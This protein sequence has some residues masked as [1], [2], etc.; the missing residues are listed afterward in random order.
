MEDFELKVVEFGED[1]LA[2]LQ[3]IAQA[4]LY[5]EEDPRSINYKR[6]L[7]RPRINWLKICVF[8]LIPFVVIAVVFAILYTCDIDFIV[9][10]GIALAFFL[11]YIVIITKRT[12]ICI[13]KLYQ[14]FAP[15]S[16]R[17]KCR[18]EPSCSEY[19]IISIEK[20]GLRKGMKAGIKRLKRC[21]TS[22]GGYDYP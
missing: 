5:D 7:V 3:S 21:N 13:I 17:N 1:Q 8:S 2:D 6:K 16:I 4:M 11:V 10:V 12:I 20:Y 15:E 19:M 9:G 22:D 14:K 18:F